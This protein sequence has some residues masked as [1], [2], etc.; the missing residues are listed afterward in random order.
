MIWDYKNYVFQRNYKIWRKEVEISHQNI[1][2]AMFVWEEGVDNS[3]HAYTSWFTLV[4]D[5]G[6]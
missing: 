4:S 1:L 2:R 3:L 6:L 5:L